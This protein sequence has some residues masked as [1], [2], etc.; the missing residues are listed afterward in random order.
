MALL[1]T[2]EGWRLFTIEFDRH[3]KEERAEMIQLY[4]LWV[5]ELEPEILYTVYPYP[6][7]VAGIT[8]RGW[9]DPVF[10]T[11]GRSVKARSSFSKISISR[12]AA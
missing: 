1:T 9:A 12:Y 10:A 2:P 8:V 5:S 11:S 6:L 3:L 7:L 4:S